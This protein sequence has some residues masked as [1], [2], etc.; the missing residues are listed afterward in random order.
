L[1]KWNN[2]ELEALVMDLIGETAVPCSIDYV[3]KH[4]NLAWG[5]A[6]AILLNLAVGNKIKVQK[7]TTGLV[8]WKEHGLSEN[9]T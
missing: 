2:P 9:A 1:Q 7:T 8:F 6:R 4:F 5:T 3:A